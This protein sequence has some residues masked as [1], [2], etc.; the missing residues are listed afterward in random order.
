[1]KNWQRGFIPWRQGF[2]SPKLICRFRRQTEVS[3]Q[4][5]PRRLQDPEK[6]WRSQKLWRR[7]RDPPEV[8]KEAVSQHAKD[9]VRAQVNSFSIGA[10]WAWAL[11]WPNDIPREECTT[12]SM[13]TISVRHLICCSFH[14]FWSPIA[15]FSN[16][17]RAR[18]REGKGARHEGNG[19]WEDLRKARIIQQGI[20]TN[21]P[22]QWKDRGVMNSAQVMLN[23]S[24]MKQ[25]FKVLLGKPPKCE[26]EVCWI[27]WNWNISGTSFF[28]EV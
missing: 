9:A 2:P 15:V 7:L 14:I 28:P 5:F 23:L 8:S 13:L 10:A 21:Q 6:L 26:P 19:N 22:V 1:M 4:K 25:P 16:S 17:S 20:P 27:P 11:G 24:T 3:H 12:H 18:P